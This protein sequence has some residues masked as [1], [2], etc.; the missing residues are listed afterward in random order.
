MSSCSSAI[1]SGLTSAPVVAR[2]TPFG[3]AQRR[4]AF[5]VDDVEPRAFGVQEPNDVVG[6]A[7]GRTDH[8]RDAHRVHGVDVGAVVETDLDG[9]EQRLRGLRVGLRDGPVDAGG[10]HER[11]GAFERRD[12]GVGAVRE[13]QA[14]RGRVA[15]QRRAQERRLSRHVHPRQVAGEAGAAIRPFARARVDVRAALDQQ[16]DDRRAAPRDRPARRPGRDGAGRDCGT[17]RRRTAAC[18]PRS[19]RR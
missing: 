10:G 4:T 1:V 14:H 12:V 2:N 15:R 17:R 8:R 5:L 7:V 3:P 16:R 9:I 6:A 19:R 11:R 18:G 13:Q